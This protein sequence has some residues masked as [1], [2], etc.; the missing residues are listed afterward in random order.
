MRIILYFDIN[1]GQ[2]ICG[3]SEISY[4]LLLVLMAKGYTI[5]RA[6]LKVGYTVKLT[7]FICC[8]FITFMALFIYQAQV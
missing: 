4:L 3:L 1:L 6:R 7:V 5:T 8:Y 2:L